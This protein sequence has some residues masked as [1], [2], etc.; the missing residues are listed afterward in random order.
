MREIDRIPAYLIKG[1]ALRKA[2]NE[3]RTAEQEEDNLWQRM[4]VQGVPVLVRTANRRK[5]SGR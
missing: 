1:L 2:T 5:P 4:V 3:D